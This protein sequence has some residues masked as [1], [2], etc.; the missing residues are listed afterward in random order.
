MH[1]YSRAQLQRH[2]CMIIYMGSV[3][4]MYIFRYVSDLCTYV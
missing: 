1:A 4:G 2:V 3:T